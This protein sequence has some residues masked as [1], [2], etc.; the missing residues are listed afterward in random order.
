MKMLEANGTMLPTLPVSPAEGERVELRGSVYRIRRMSGFAFVILRTARELVQTLYIPDKAGFSLDTLAEGDC[1][2]AWGEAAPEPRSKRGYDIVLKGVRRLSG[3]D[4]EPP[5]VINKK[6]LGVPLDVN[7]S[8]RSLCLRNHRERCIFRVQH[9]LGEAFRAFLSGR[10]F[11][12]IHTPKLVSAGAEGGANIFSLDYF[13]RPAYLA[14]S[15]QLYKQAMVGVFERVYEIGPVFRAEKHDTS[16]HLNEYT[17]VDFEMG[18][19][20]GFEDVMAMEAAMLAHAFGHLRD[21]FALELEELGAKLPEPGAIPCVQFM[22][23]KE[24]MASKLG[25][26]V[27]DYHDFEPAEEQ[28]LCDY[29]L[30]ETGSEFVFVT[31][32]PS[33]KRP[34]YAMDDPADPRYT[35]SF[36]LL[37][38]GLEVTTGGQ[39]IHNYSEQVE[40]MRRRGMNELEFSHWLSCHKA[41]L[42]P[43]GG[44]GLGLE[45]LTM[46]LL[47]F[48][49]VRRA[50]LYPRDIQRLEP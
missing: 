30:R 17:S 33:E 18:Y 31:H 19:I 22:E 46:K 11:T 26:K 10:G 1:L 50:C 29:I 37:C 13:G 34:F 40:K 12:G 14:Q 8:N 20:R 28:A 9:G 32:Y 41:G 35:L 45:R 23:G 2:E 48:D 27:T 36:D 42:P 49:N 38:R 5:L 16:R 7:L 3:A 44:L 47:G 6:E 25:R 15:P 4:G 21:N 39:R 43:H 24:L